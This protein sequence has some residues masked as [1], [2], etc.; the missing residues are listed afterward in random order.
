MPQDDPTVILAEHPAASLAIPMNLGADY[1]V[2]TVTMIVGRSDEAK[3]QLIEALTDA[4]T[5]AGPRGTIVDV[6]LQE[7]PRNHW[8]RHGQLASDREP[9]FEI[10]I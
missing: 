7:Q 8:A 4:V 1:A 10:E 2:V 3:R 6:L 5:A 9:D